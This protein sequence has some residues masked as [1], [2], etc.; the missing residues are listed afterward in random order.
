M[1]DSLAGRLHAN[2]LIIIVAFVRFVGGW[3]KRVLGPG[4]M[5]LSC[6]GGLRGYWFT[7]FALV[8]FYSGGRAV[9]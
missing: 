3:T 5:F 2:P 9:G 4:A 8:Y 6:A 1:M 7:F